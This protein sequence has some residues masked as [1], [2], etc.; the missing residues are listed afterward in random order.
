MTDFAEPFLLSHT[1]STR[2]TAYNWGNK[3]ITRDGQTHVVWLDAIAT[4][5][6]RTYDHESQRWRDGAHRRGR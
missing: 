4:V 2:A 3:I 1:G 6:G 5:C